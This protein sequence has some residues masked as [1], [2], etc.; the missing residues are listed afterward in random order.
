MINTR[1]LKGS[2]RLWPPKNLFRS[3][4][5]YPVQ[6]FMLRTPA[7]TVFENV[8]FCWRYG[9]M[10]NFVRI[11]WR[12]SFCSFLSTNCTKLYRVCT[13]IWSRISRRIVWHAQNLRLRQTCS[14]SKAFF[15][16]LA[17]E[18]IVFFAIPR[19]FSSTEVVVFTYVVEHEKLHLTV[20]SIWQ[21]GLHFILKK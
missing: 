6:F 17:L 7:Q 11:S 21:K 16:F 20:H 8:E 5:D 19:N 18:K 3:F 1:S 15:D 9:K 4:Y 14:R 10:E 13:S 12:D 2:K